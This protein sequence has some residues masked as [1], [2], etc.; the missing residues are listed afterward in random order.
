MMLKHFMRLFE[1]KIN[2]EGHKH[3][4]QEG[5]LFLKR[6][7]GAFILIQKKSK[8]MLEMSKSVHE[9]VLFTFDS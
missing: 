1:P 4:I 5:T 2:Q 6:I 9:S 3:L 7:H 8:K